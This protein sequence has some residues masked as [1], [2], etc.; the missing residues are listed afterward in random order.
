MEIQ[1][2]YVWRK[3]KEVA[4]ADR[5]I[6]AKNK[7]PWEA[8]ELMLDYW[9]QTNPEEYESFVIDVEGTRSSRANKFGASKDKNSG[10]RYTLDIP[11][12]VWQMIV[13]VFG[14]K[15]I[16]DPYSK[17]FFRDFGKRFPAF[18]VAERS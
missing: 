18:K 13:A 3:A 5:V 14:D 10:M 4:F 11:T 12:Q 9:K 17:N 7:D 15:E 8:I 6:Q 1:P 16:I 2:E